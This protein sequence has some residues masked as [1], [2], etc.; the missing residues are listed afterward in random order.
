MLLL[1]TVLTISKSFPQTLT[2]IQAKR[3]AEFGKV[4]GLLKYYHP[5]LAT[6]NLN[7][8]D[9]LRNYISRIKDCNSDQVFNSLLGS[10]FENIGNYPV[11]RKFIKSE[12]YYTQTFET[13]R[14]LES[15]LL[16]TSIKKNLENL[17]LFFRPQKNNLVV[18]ESVTYDTDIIHNN[19]KDN[20]TTLII[21]WNIIKYE[22]PHLK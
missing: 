13:G 16:D 1:F 11:N 14:I 10:L 9:T 12:K 15:Q 18:R 21:A 7:W 4:W 3:V 6:G 19:E 20:L 2:E 22:A 5:N 17:L 8:N